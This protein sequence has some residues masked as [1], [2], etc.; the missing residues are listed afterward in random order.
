MQNQA[1]FGAPKLLKGQ[2][3]FLKGF[4]THFWNYTECKRIKQFKYFDDPSA[5]NLYELLGEHAI[6]EYNAPFFRELAEENEI[7][8]MYPPSV[9]NDLVNLVLPGY[10]FLV[11]TEISVIEISA[12]EHPS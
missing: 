12:P 2:D 9:L 6:D 4:R 5:H 8:V 1:P 3:D 7:K 11:S 10:G